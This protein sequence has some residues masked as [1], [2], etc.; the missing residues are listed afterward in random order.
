M[1]KTNASQQL[2]NQLL[3]FKPTSDGLAMGVEKQ[4]PQTEG[5]MRAWMLEKNEAGEFSCLLKQVDDSILASEGVNVD[6]AYSTI[7]FKDGLAMLNKSPV[8]RTWPMIAGIDF[9]GT[10]IDGEYAGQEVLANGHGMGETSLGALADKARVPADWLIPVPA[11][12]TAK[13]AMAIGTAGY[14]AMLCVHALEDQGLTPESGPVLVTGATGG[15]GTFAVM[16]L[17]KKGFEVIASTGRA[18]EE[19]HLKS[20]GA[21]SIID[22]AELSE[23]GK[24]LGREKWAGVVDSVGSHTLANAIAQTKYGGCVAACGLAQGFDLPAT[25]MPFI[26]RGV[27]LAGVDS[28]QAPRAKRVRAWEGLAELI[29]PD[30][31]DAVTEVRPM[32]QALATAEGILSNTYKGRVVIDVKG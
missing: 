30:E 2:I 1:E 16:L 21:S 23:K 12:L 8:V 18:S 7:N 5:P 22:R 15:V 9:A 31:I 28:V 27:T 17:A 10:A 13:H 32:D 11:P 26:L 3:G 25:V 29:S 14:T 19:A 6:V 20:L 24:P 4:E